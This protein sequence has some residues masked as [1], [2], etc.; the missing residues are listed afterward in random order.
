M[1][2][3]GAFIALMADVR[4]PRRNTPAVQTLDVIESE[5]IREGF[6]SLGLDSH[7]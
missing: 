3:E 5:G 6:D 1:T 2:T 4:S 7:Y